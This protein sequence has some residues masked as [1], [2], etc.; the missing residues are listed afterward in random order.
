M[1]SNPYAKRPK[2]VYPAA[3]PPP[4]DAASYAAAY[5]QAYPGA[6]AASTSAYPAQAGPAYPQQATYDPSFA[7]QSSICASCPLLLLLPS[8]LR[9]QRH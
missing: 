1:S 4:A 7:Q 2:P 8:S 9:S 6:A 5:P 3:P